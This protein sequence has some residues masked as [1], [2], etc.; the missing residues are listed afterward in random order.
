M[1]A[2]EEAFLLSRALRKI[3]GELIDRAA[4]LRREG[5]LDQE[6]YD[7]VSAAYLAII[8]KAIE[9][10]NTASN[11]LLE[12]L[13]PY[14]E[15]LRQITTSLNEHRERLSAIGAVVRVSTGMT[16]VAAA[17]VTLIAAPSPATL[18]TAGAALRRAYEELD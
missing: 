18:G 14:L 4:V 5:H 17:L 12:T 9:V 7:Q 6:A 8:N 3:A 10:N 11:A 1:S 13:E 15:P 16:M 2:I